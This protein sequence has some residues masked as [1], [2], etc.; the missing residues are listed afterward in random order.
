MMRY[1]GYRTVH[2]CLQAQGARVGFHVFMMTDLFSKTTN[3][4]EQFDLIK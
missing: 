2:R 4:R 3:L 1:L